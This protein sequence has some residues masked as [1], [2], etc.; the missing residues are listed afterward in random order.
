MKSSSRNVRYSGIPF[1]STVAIYCIYSSVPEFR[2]NQEFFLKKKIGTI[3]YL[4]LFRNLTTNLTLIFLVCLFDNAFRKRNKKT[5]PLNTQSI[6]SRYHK[7]AR[8]KLQKHQHI[9]DSHVFTE[10]A[11]FRFPIV[12][13]NLPHFL[14]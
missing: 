6:F 9:C 1:T 10:T 3:A 14:V 2:V 4:T 5:I 7:A 12:Q 8:D 11:S 13:P